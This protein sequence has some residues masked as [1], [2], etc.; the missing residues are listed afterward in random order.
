[1]HSGA[2]QQAERT[3]ATRLLVS[4]ILC[5]GTPLPS[6]CLRDDVSLLFASVFVG[7]DPLVSRFC[8][9]LQGKFTKEGPA[10][11]RLP[12]DDRRFA[13]MQTMAAFTTLLVPPPIVLLY[14]DSV[15]I[16]YMKELHYGVFNNQSCA[17][18]DFSLSIGVAQMKKCPFHLWCTNTCFRPIFWF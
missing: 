15:M 12:F 16:K 17:K 10:R 7:Y 18:S 9:R 2:S 3:I 11:D 5:V 6:L 13:M 8:S 4:A 14:I 1:V